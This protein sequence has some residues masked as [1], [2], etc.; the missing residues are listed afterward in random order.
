MTKDLPENFRLALATGMRTIWGPTKGARAELLLVPDYLSLEELFGKERV[1]LKP[2]GGKPM[3]NPE[4][5]AL[6]L[7]HLL[8]VIPNCE[9]IAGPCPRCDRFYIKKRASQ[10]VY[11]S[12]RCGNAQ[13]AIDRTSR[14]RDKEHSAKL[15]RAKR[16]IREWKHARPTDEWKQW[17]SKRIP[18]MTPKFL[19][20]AV[21][22]GELKEPAHKGRRK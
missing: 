3:L 9:K 22:K 8:T 7:F 11:C 20:R 12:R 10:K 15:A 13:T 17:V 4:T 5:E 1:W 16:A 2:A 14:R 19:T 6:C 18:E 21:N